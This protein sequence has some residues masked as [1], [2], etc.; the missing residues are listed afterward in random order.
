[1]MRR[2]LSLAAA[3]LVLA[4]WCAA[5]AEVTDVAGVEYENAVQLADTRLQPNGAG[6][7]YKAV[8]N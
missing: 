2:H 7:R 5:R 4:L 6:I 1:M 8:F 3:G